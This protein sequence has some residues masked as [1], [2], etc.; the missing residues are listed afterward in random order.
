ME[1]LHT[2]KSIKGVGEKTEKLFV[3]LG[4]RSTD[5]LIHYYPRDYDAYEPPVRL[6][7]LVPGKK[8]SVTGMLMQAPDVKKTGMRAVVT[9]RIKDGDAY[10]TLTWFNMPF[11]RN[12]LKRGSVFVFRGK[13]TEKTGV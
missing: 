11:L 7:Q 8:W 2:I 3:K 10:L 4:I 5:D 9:T 12:V 1:T 13:V 6:C